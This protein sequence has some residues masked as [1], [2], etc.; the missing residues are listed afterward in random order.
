MSIH[1]EFEIGVNQAFEHLIQTKLDGK[2]NVDNLNYLH[3]YE[4]NTF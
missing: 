1:F 3:L 2:L 4:G